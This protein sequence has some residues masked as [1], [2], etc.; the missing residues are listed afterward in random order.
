[1][2]LFKSKPK[3]F[4]GIDVGASAI[5]MVELG[6]EDERYKLV[7]YA[8]CS[9]EKNL[10][11]NN[12]QLNSKSFLIPPEKMAELIKKVLEKAEIKTR[13]AYFSIP[14]SF[15]FSTLI[16]F[17]DMP[18]S[19]LAS[20]VPYE[21]Q[22]Y[23]PLPIS[24]LALDWSV[25]SRSKQKVQKDQNSQKDQDGQKNQNSQEETSVEILLVAAP[26]KLVAD[27]EKIVNLAGL[28][29][30][31]IEEETFSL[32]RALV[33]NDKSPVVLIDFGARSI[34]VSVV[35]QGYVW[36]CHSLEIGGVK[37]TKKIAD[38]LGMD[39][40]QAED[41]KKSFSQNKD[42]NLKIKSAVYQNL[43]PAI[44]EIK[45]IIENYQKKYSKKIDRCILV[46]GSSEIAGFGE[47][48]AEKAGLDVSL[49]NPFARVAYPQK[50][51]S[52]LKK[53]GPIMAVAVGL[54]M[55]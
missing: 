28:K 42:N 44:V 37:L 48:L 6:K 55:R 13:E 40:N 24:E 49:G 33:G 23:M 26:K 32:A 1:M 45:R 8:I 39:F 14:A 18:D 2:F 52:V 19:E 16:S 54:A 47:Y 53:L 38:D 21:A 17:P 20:A 46:G 7:N 36:L 43:S 12:Y 25:V 50:L 22:K 29:L 27:C 51:D 15:S 41:F 31:S 5:K 3:T 30:S 4:L 11:D 9:F 35:D 34:N 10:R